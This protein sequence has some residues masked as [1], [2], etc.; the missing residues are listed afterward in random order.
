MAV[1]KY[2]FTKVIGHQM[3][4]TINYSAT[5]FDQQRVSS[6]PTTNTKELN[7]AFKLR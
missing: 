5:L 4:G 7:V 3:H 6:D 1:N 2:W